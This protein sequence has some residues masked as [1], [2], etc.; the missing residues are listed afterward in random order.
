[1]SHE[2]FSNTK[3]LSNFK[4]RNSSSMSVSNS[5]KNLQVVE[6]KDVNKIEGKAY[7]N[8]SEES[9]VSKCILF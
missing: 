5:K 4:N 9:E 7:H 1:L 2:G 8:S 6:L 3:N